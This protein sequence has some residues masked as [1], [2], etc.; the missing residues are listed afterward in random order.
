MADS[1]T[2]APA[3]SNRGWMVFFLVLVALTSAAVAL[4]WAYNVKQQLKRE[5]LEA[6]RD[7]WEKN[8]PANYDLHYTKQRG[9]SPSE[10]FLIKVRGGKVVSAELDG[11][12][13]EPRLYAAH[14]MD[15]LF[16]DMDQFLEIDG[17]PDSPRAF[18]VASFD[19]ADGHVQ[20]YVRSVSATRQRVEITVQLKRVAETSGR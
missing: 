3:T 12:P 2:A 20:H 15:G 11:H 7:L 9:D 5:R 16:N 1:T 13:L 17:K 4:N 8:R 10:S 18:V 14:D 6:A 19:A